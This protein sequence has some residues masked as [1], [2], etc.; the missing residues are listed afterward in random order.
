MIKSNLTDYLTNQMNIDELSVTEIEHLIAESPS[1]DLYRMLL[2]SKMKGLNAHDVALVSSDRLLFEDII[3]GKT[4]NYQD[5]TPE[6]HIVQ[7][8]V[9]SSPVY[10]EKFITDT[11]EPEKSV[12]INVDTKT[13]QLTDDTIADIVHS[14]ESIQEVNPVNILETSPQ[15]EN[16]VQTSTP[17]I[18]GESTDMHKYEEG[19]EETLSV[20]LS[21]IEITQ[22]PKTGHKAKNKKNSFKL[23]E[24]GGLSSFSLWLMS[25]ERDDI[26]KRLKKEAKRDQK[27]QL[28]A[29]ARKSITKSDEI[30][31][32]SLAQILENQ[33]HFDEAKKMYEQLMHKYPEK[34]RYFAAKIDKLINS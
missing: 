10:Q 7:N 33:K 25:L 30:I 16:I 6:K 9:V 22:Q 21:E 17:E 15:I 2:M 4:Q 28:A 31:S 23:K 18:I 27:R 26:E 3:T 20:S 29:S 19:K 1:S 8:H 5:R 12:G 11:V 13:E 14:G 32:E 24:F 34:S